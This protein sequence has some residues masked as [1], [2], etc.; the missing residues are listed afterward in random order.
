MIVIS[1]R[2]RTYSPGTFGRRYLEM[3]IVIASGFYSLILDPEKQKDPLKSAASTVGWTSLIL[4]GI[5]LQEKLVM[6]LIERGWMR[7]IVQP[8]ILLEAVYTAGFMAS[9]YIDD[10][11]GIRNY[12]SFLGLAKRNPST[13]VAVTTT[14]AI[15]VTEH[16][17]SSETRTDVAKKW[18]QGVEALESKYQPLFDAF[19][20]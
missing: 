4:A 12:H 13:A 19:G 14:S 6:K 10:E 7:A 5:F 8:I 3:N 20:N 15:I 2:N 16:L 1:W 17:T 9:Y 11:E 18:D